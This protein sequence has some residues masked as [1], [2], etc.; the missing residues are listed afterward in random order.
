MNDCKENL[1]PCKASF[2]NHKFAVT[3]FKSFVLLY[4]LPWWRLVSWWTLLNLMLSVIL[5]YKWNNVWHKFATEPFSYMNVGL[6]EHFFSHPMWK[7]HHVIML[8]MKNHGHH[9][10]F[11]LIQISHQRWKK[12][13][14]LST[15]PEWWTNSSKI[16]TIKCGGPTTASHGLQWC[17]MSGEQSVLRRKRISLILK[18]GRMPFWGLK[19]C[20]RAK[21]KR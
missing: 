2:K 1:T 19:T 4:L 16:F 6:S 20:L 18:Q 15:A 8:P 13:V 12:M 3:S 17:E 5:H 21:V 14:S 10:T 7:L 9:M 11:Q